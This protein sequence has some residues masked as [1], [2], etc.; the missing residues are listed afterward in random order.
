MNNKVIANGRTSIWESVKQNCSKLSLSSTRFNIILTSYLII[1]FNYIFLAKVDELHTTPGM[2]HLFFMMSAVVLL[3]IVLHFFIS[4]ITYKYLH[5]SLVALIL[6]S[7]AGSYFYM[8]TYGIM[9]DKSMAQN[10]LET[11]LAEAHEVM[12]FSLFSSVFLFGAIPALIAIFIK[13]NY[14]PIIKGTLINIRNILVSFVA[15]GLIAAV[16][17]QDY[18]SLFRGNPFIRDMAVPINFV[19]ATKGVIKDK[20]F[21]SH[22]DLITMGTDAKRGPLSQN[23]KKRVISVLVVGETARAEN[24]SL[25]GYERIT[26]PRLS[27]LITLNM[28]NFSSCGTTTAI[29]VPCLFAKATRNKFD[30]TAAD[31]TENLLD[32]VQRAGMPVY[33]LDNNSGCKDVCNRVT[34]ID[35][36]NEKDPELC[37]GKEQGLLE[38][39]CYDEI[40]V[41]AL[42]KTIAS[43]NDDMFIVLHQKGSH[44]PAYYLRAPSQFQEFKPACESAELQFCSQ[45]EIKNAYD[46][47]LLYTDF[48]VSEVINELKFRSDEFDSSLIYVSDHGESLGENRIFLHG[49]PYMIA[50]SEQTHVPFVSWIPENYAQRFGI[51]TACMKNKAEQ[52]FSHDN[53][54]SSLLGW[55]N[56]ETKEYTPDLD[57]FRSC[58]TKSM[59]PA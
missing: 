22:N 9:I 34:F 44:G 24:F 46:N 43:S 3:F 58:H 48:I 32:I 38:T 52:T 6:I 16:Y 25:N 59:N 36:S 49:M 26:N 53:M 7:S 10:V 27:P 30:S 18:A 57:M 13:V 8:D 17:Y 55:M 50:P 33:W 51:D 29:S 31:F 11:D 37:M 15:L 4:L 19:N 40:L 2:P 56:I 41:K 45:E 20:F 39:E 12:T 14:P 47:S 42:K 28:N 21:H 54:F 23:N 1:A 35:V 5:K